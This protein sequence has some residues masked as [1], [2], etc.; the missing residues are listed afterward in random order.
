LILIVLVVGRLGLL[1]GSEIGTEVVSAALKWK[2]FLSN[3]KKGALSSGARLLVKLDFGEKE[4]KECG[5]LK[6]LES[7]AAGV[8]VWGESFVV[9][10]ACV[11]LTD[12]RSA[13][14]T[15]WN[16]D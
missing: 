2:F 3:N 13:S 4:T 16:I 1:D 8:A 6:F 7:V 9:E 11:A 12:R 5:S 15:W 14:S 10:M